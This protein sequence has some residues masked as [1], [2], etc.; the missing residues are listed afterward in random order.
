MH[1]LLDRSVTYI[2]TYEIITW[3]QQAD[4]PLAPGTDLAL[5]PARSYGTMA[6]DKQK[7]K[8]KSQLN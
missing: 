8:D 1:Q 7:T 3:A 5:R 6:V 4:A 2:S